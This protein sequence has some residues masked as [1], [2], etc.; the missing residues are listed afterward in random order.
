MGQLPAGPAVPVGLGWHP[1]A[2]DFAAAA[3]AYL[4]AQAALATDGEPDTGPGH[5]LSSVG[6]DRRRTTRRPGGDRTIRALAS[7]QRGVGNER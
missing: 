6:G 5:H 4:P 7:Q 1:A 2:D 3:H